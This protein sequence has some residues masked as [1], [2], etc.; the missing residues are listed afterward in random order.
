VAKTQFLWAF[1]DFTKLGSITVTTKA[2]VNDC[3]FD[4]LDPS[5]SQIALSCNGTEFVYISF[6]DYC[7]KF[8][9]ILI[10]GF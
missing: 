10:E 7:T 1:T 2:S 4:S 9:Y 3:I 5:L 8:A 6:K